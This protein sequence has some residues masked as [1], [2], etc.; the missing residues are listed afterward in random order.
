MRPLR[1]NHRYTNSENRSLQTFLLEIGKINLLTTEQEVQLASEIEKGCETALT[2]LVSANLRFLVSVAKQYEGFGL[3]LGELIDEG[4]FGLVKAARRFD[5]KRGF[6]FISYAVWWMRQSMLKAIE[7][8]GIAISLP[9]NQAA[10][11]TKIE[12][13]SSLM[14][15]SLLR[16]PTA[17]ELAPHL[18]YSVKV[19][20]SNQKYYSRTFISKDSAVPG[21][22]SSQEEIMLRD[23]S[24]SPDSMI[25]KQ[26]SVEY[27]KQLLQLLTERERSILNS[28][29]G[30]GE[31]EMDLQQIADRFSLSKSRVMQIISDA[32]LKL[33]NIAKRY[34]VA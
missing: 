9:A 33:Q 4:Y 17:A 24:E 15:H 11:H 34:D 27:A 16:E 23:E 1:I 14:E 13:Q 26:I 7:E 3:P 22:D 8:K 30:L 19:I 6:K 29:Y 10:L 2:K 25:E 12:S 5:P 20:E 31:D 21:R 18:D 28:Y 32:E